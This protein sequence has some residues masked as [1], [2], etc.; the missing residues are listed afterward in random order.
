M[1]P[2]GSNE[3]LAVAVASDAMLTSRACWTY[4]GA[5]TV[6]VYV[7]AARSPIM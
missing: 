1:I 2:A 6:R 3:K 4:S 5:E 7:P